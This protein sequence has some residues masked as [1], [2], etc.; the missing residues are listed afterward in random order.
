MKRIAFV[1]LM[2][3]VLLS[4][5]AFAEPLPRTACRSVDQSFARTYDWL[6]VGLFVAG[7]I[8]F[9]LFIPSILGRYFWFLTYPT[10]R[11]AV[12]A[13]I[14]LSVFTIVWFVPP[15][16]A[17]FRYLPWPQAVRPF[18]V[19]P[20]YPI[21]C[22]SGDFVTAGTAF[23]LISTGKQLVA[24]DWIN[25]LLVIPL[26]FAIAVAVYWL[27]YLKCRAALGIGR[28]SEG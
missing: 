20:A 24:Y 12:T 8:V 13:V 27:T 16:L 14:A 1:A 4:L 6:A 10:R 3:V 18:A 23:G 19:T 28:Q 22:S 25:L 5:S 9:P 2:L 21:S 17:N 26:F 15:L 11:W 7:V